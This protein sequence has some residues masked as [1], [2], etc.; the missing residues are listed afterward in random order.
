MAL[1]YTPY[2]PISMMHSS[3]TMHPLSLPNHI[4]T[5]TYS[6]IPYHSLSFHIIP[7]HSFTFIYTH[8]H[9]HI[10]YIITY[11]Y[12]TYTYITYTYITYKYITY[13]Y[14]TYTYITYTYIYY[15]TSI[16]IMFQLPFPTFFVLGIG[17]RGTERHQQGTA[18]VGQSRW[19]GTCLGPGALVEW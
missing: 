7:L 3:S 6:Y 15:I 14:I 8:H 19:P 2:L 13:T 16:A 18:Q 5:Y 1:N 4:C 12:I 9:N 17:H 10:S 11:T